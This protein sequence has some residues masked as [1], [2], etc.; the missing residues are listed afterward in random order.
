MDEQLKALLE[1][2]NALKSGQEE[3]KERMENM[4]RTQEEFKNEL[5]EGMQK[6]LDYTKNELKERMEKCQEELK[7]SLEKKIDNVEEKINS[8]EEKIALKVEEKTA[9]VEAKIRK[10]VEKVEERIREQVDER[11][12]GVFENFSLISQP[13]LA[14]PVSVPA[15]PISVKLSTYDGKTNWE[16]YKTQFCIISEANGFNEGVKACQLAASLRDEN[17]TP[18]NR[19][20][21]ACKHVFEVERLTQLGFSDHPATVRETISLQKV[22]RGRHGLWRAVRMAVDVQDLKSALLYAPKLRLPPA[23]RKVHHSHPRS[24]GD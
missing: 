15:L 3:T 6:G 19:K 20:K 21:A 1:D 2:I 7:G 14:S 8:V 16:V 9:V 13:V 4:Q 12:E 24:Y 11:I 22:F 18:E 10:K 5:K 23:S 17:K